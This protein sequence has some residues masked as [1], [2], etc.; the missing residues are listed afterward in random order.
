MTSQKIA[1]LCALA[2]HASVSVVVD[3]MANVADLSAAA[4]AA[5]VEVKVLVAIATR[6]DRIGVE[7]GQPAVD[8][9]K[10][11]DGSAGLTFDGFKTHEGTLE[12][13]DVAALAEESRAWIRRALDAREAAEAAA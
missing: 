11:A 1:R 2:R 13:T 7:P 9:A 5:G 3:S 12:V 8:L 4:S 10:A 6:P